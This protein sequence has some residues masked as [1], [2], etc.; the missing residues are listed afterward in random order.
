MLPDIAGGERCKARSNSCRL[1]DTEVEAEG[2]R[3]F[4][5]IKARDERP[6]EAYRKIR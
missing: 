5:Q 2:H 6:T 4:V 1:K 3:G